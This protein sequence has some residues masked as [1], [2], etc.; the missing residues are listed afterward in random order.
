M[1]T[2]VVWDWNG[3]LY[4]DFHVVVKAAA[5]ACTSIGGPPLDAAAYRALFTRP[6]QR[7]YA[8]VLGRPVTEN[9]WRAVNDVYLAAYREYQP[10]A[11]LAADAGAALASVAAAGRTQ[12]LLSMSDHK[13]LVA[14]VR[15]LGID[16]AFVRVDG[17]RARGGDGKTAHLLHHLEAIAPAIDGEILWLATRRTT[18]PPPRRQV[19]LRA[20]GGRAPSA[21]G[22]DGVQRSDCQLTR[23][24]AGARRG[25]SP[26]SGHQHDR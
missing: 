21:R 15:R 14:L 8:A 3:T 13:E 19:S 24:R 17:L 20:D 11:S 9:E 25:R 22:A 6:V 4:D 5:R 18:R 26:S 23:L 1:V 10:P 12:W 16:N 7:F 2:H